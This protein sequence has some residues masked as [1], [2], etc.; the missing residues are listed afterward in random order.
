MPRI[1]QCVTQARYNQAACDTGI[2][3]SHFGLRGMYVHVNKCRV[4]IDEQ[5][6][7]RVAVAAEQVKIGTPQRPDQQL[8]PHGPT[9][10]KKILHH[11]RTARIGGQRRKA[12]QV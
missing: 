9:I 7:S 10:Y 3:K 1:C 8:V 5:R 12:G 6:R 11:R 4:A 2:A